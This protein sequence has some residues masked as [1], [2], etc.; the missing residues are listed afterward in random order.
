[1]HGPALAF[2]VSL[3]RPHAIPSDCGHPERP[4][5]GPVGRHDCPSQR[6][7]HRSRR[8]EAR[9]DVRRRRVH[10]GIAVVSRGQVDFE[11]PPCAKARGHLRQTEPVQGT[12][13]FGPSGSGAAEP[14]RTEAGRWVAPCVPQH[15]NARKARLE[16]PGL[17]Q[18]DS[19]RARGSGSSHHRD[20]ASTRVPIHA[21]AVSAGRPPTR[22]W[23]S[24]RR[25]GG[26]GP[27]QAALR[28]VVFASTDTDSAKKKP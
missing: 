2:A 10:H 7:A 5:G 11:K 24:E 21:F 28:G 14:V 19:Q 26:T 23:S 6:G 9:R 17:G 3:R 25:R 15:G 20:L 12:V 27:K 4:N 18:V 13:E 22:P 1:M 16:Q 8:V